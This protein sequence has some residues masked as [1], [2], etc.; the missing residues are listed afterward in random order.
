MKE[1]KNLKPMD[2]ANVTNRIKNIAEQVTNSQNLELVQ[3]EVVG[4]DS[5]PTVRIF[6][7]KTGG[8]THDD[9]VAVSREVEAILDADDFMPSSYTLE[10]SSPGLERGLFSL[11]DFEKYAGR[12]AKIK[13][14]E[15]INGQKNFRGSIVGIEDE[16]ILF[17]DKTNGFVR[18]PF[19]VVGKANLEIDLDEEFRNAAQRG[20]S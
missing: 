2:K 20:E 4:A 6:I 16:N 17:A 7:D 14:R 11:K 10:V 1:E 12:L 9:C 13:T 8:V 5:N 3:I 18:I 15:A 19:A